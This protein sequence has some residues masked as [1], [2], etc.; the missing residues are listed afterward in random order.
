[1][2]DVHLLA[3]APVWSKPGSNQVLK[4]GGPSE[5][6]AGPMDQFI[7]MNLGP[8]LGQVWLGLGLNLG[9][10]PNP[11]IPSEMQRNGRI[12]A[13]NNHDNLFSVNK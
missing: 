6:R 8:N 9:S 13:H 1:M 2:T 4:I 11:T 12:G 5:P 3:F 7:V 10:E